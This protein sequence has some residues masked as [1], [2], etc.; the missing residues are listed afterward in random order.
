MKI[1]ILIL[2][3][4]INGLESVVS[5]SFNDRGDSS[6]SETVTYTYSTSNGYQVDLLGWTST[7]DYAKTP[8]LNYIDILAQIVT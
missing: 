7:R 3:T 5:M 8:F 1:R 2:D 6:L 4:C